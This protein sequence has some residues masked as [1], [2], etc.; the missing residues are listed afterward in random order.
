MQIVEHFA[1]DMT[2][3]YPMNALSPLP[4][5]IAPFH[6]PPLSTPYFTREPLAEA[7][8]IAYRFKQVHRAA[9]DAWFEDLSAF[10]LAWPADQPYCALLDVRG[11]EHLI[12]AQAY[13]VARQMTYLRPELPGRVAV[14]VGRGIIAPVMNALIRNTIAGHAR[15]RL[16]FST[17]EMALAWLL[18]PR[19]D[20]KF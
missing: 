3:I 14:L 12:S 1:P 2:T 6:I 18:S 9:A 15:Q 4:V 19:H 11:R 8:V 13:S 20:S 16:L 10:I 17:E 7:R 5:S